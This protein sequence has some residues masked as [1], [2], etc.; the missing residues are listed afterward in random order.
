MF[1]TLSALRKLLTPHPKTPRDKALLAK[2][3]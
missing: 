3:R 1:A 2:R